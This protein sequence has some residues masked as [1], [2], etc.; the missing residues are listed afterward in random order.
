MLAFF[1][2]LIPETNSNRALQLNCLRIL[3]NSCADRDANRQRVIEHPLGLKP[4]VE[5]VK[6]EETSPIATAVVWNIC[7]E[8]GG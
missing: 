6:D 1:H 2:D 8:Y 7:N 3:A 4:V 5:L